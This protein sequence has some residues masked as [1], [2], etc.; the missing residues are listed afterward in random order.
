MARTSFK[1]LTAAIRAPFSK[2]FGLAQNP[3]LIDYSYDNG[4]AQRYSNA[5]DTADVLA[6]SVDS[7]NTLLFGQEAI[8]PQGQ[9]YTFNI[10]ANGSI[11]ATTFFIADRTYY[12]QGITEVH[13]TAGSDGSAVTAVITRERGVLAP[14]AGTA[15]M[16][17]TFNLKGTANTVQSATLNGTVNA[18]LDPVLVLNPGDR[19]SFKT[20]G[21][22]TALAGVVVTVYL[23]PGCKSEIA[24]YFVHANA[25]LSTQTFFVANRDFLVKGAYLYFGTAFGA[26]ITIDCT[27]DTSTNAPGAG[28]SI[29]SAAVTVDGST[30]AAQTTN[31]LTLGTGPFTLR[32]GDRLAI[33]YSATTT[34]AD[35][36][37]A[38]VLQPIYKRKE[39]TWQLGPNGQQQVDQCFFAADRDYE[40][41]DLSCTFATAAGGAA[42]LLVTIDKGTTAPG[43]G[44]AVHTDNTSAG[45]DLNAT[46]NT[47]QI[48]TLNTL[49]N[50][51]LA[52]GDRLGLKHTGTAQSIANVAITVSLIPR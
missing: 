45:F 42:K 4:F 44:N 25:D 46:G 43:A 26:A 40:V 29:L 2:R 6:D 18:P 1:T 51:L 35:V 28:S 12:V 7:D 49:R 50:R 5:A 34:G 15:L 22:L 39:V 41:V 13:K 16:S 48:G 11:G 37:L 19:L 20:S 27:Q 24:S 3:N 8:N 38:V 36:C 23:T 31:A 32:A 30:L 47:V 17:N 52:A 14:G 9:A 21:T 10:A 33:K